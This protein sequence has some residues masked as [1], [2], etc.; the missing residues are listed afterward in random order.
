MTKQEKGY[1]YAYNYYYGRTLDDCY[2]KPSALKFCIWQDIREECYNNDGQVLTVL[3]Y[4]AFMFTC[5]YE[6]PSKN[7]LVVH[8]PSKRIEIA[9]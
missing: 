5:A 4:N 7:I 6:I 1:V 9:L 2:N 8:T 3:S